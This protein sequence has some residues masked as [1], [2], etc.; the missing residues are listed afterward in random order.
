MPFNPYDFTI[1]SFR[2]NF[3]E[4]GAIPD[5]QIAFQQALGSQ[6]LSI[7]KYW[8]HAPEEVQTRI[9]M[10]VIAHLATV[11]SN[12]AGAT[13]GPMTGATEGSTSVSFSAPAG[14]SSSAFWCL[15]GYGQQLWALLRPKLTPRMADGAGRIIC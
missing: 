8:G 13:A 15:T 3:P 12:G 14:A 6:Y 10:L 9:A 5:T 11:A 7:G 1:P 4:L 2:A